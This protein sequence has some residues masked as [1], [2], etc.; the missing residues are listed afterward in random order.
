[1]K[2]TTFING[3][4]NVKKGPLS[5]DTAP[6]QTAQIRAHTFANMQKEYMTIH[7]YK[8]TIQEKLVAVFKQVTPGKM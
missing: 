5:E 1:M 7:I 3:T 8:S 4:V 2:T 6:T